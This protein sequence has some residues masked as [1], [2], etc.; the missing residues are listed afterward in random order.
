MCFYHILSMPNNK[1]LLQV[2]IPSAWCD[3]QHWPAGERQDFE[4]LLASGGRS[5]APVA[6]APAEAAAALLAVRERLSRM[7][8]AE[9]AAASM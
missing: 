5:L 9:L 8:D 4:A 3:L 2:G 1:S 6:V 7:L